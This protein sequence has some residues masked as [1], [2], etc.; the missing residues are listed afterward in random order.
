MINFKITS[1]DN[2]AFI[3]VVKPTGKSIP[4]KIG[5]I[6]RADVMEILPTGGV[7]LK[8]KG[9]FLTAK[10]EVPLDKGAS[11][12]F[13][14]A[15]QPV[16]GKELRL[17]FM[18]Y[19]DETAKGQD[20]A[21]P[22]FNFKDSA[23][24]KLIQDLSNN[25][26][27]TKNPDI[28]KIQNLNAEILKALP[29]DIT[30]LPK[31]VRGQLQNL[32]QASLK[33]TGQ[34][35]QTRLEGFI[36]ELPEQIKNLP[37]VEG[38]KKDLIVSMEKLLQTPLKS[39]LQDT[40]VALEA[41]L[42]NIATLLAQTENNRDILSQSGHEEPLKAAL[43]EALLPDAKHLQL[44]PD[45]TTLKKDM[46]A[47]LLQLRQ[48]FSDEGKAVI[49]DPAVQNMTLT[50]REGAVR[51]IDGM[52]KDIE[53]FQLLSKTTDSF[54]TFLPVSW[55]EL[56]DGEVSFKKGRSDAK[57]E[58]FSCSINLDLEKFGTL[59]IRVM[60]Y[61]NE[62]SVSFKPE[63]PEF[64]KTLDSNAA[65]LQAAFREKRLNLKAVTV[66]DIN[67]HSFEQLENLESSDR[68]ISIK[69]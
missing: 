22:F 57:G 60:M 31:D 11:V 62:F 61:N 2:E 58:S 56:K 53:T 8:I 42:K 7:T 64:Q 67:D 29:S 50:Q 55:Q 12:F 9:E 48:L 36:N 21:K 27:N 45:T 32:L 24:P 43:K 16:E 28:S 13:K 35:I 33:T 66:L 47:D 59:K 26:V 10:T 18:G 49:K 3:S 69:A 34:G 1:F 65:E 52:L 19:T 30:L 63:N 41:K 51:F 40:G 17:Q 44:Q 14:V 37:F 5:E 20:I 68:M 4:L 38:L 15:G 25:I 46:K 39:V 54:Y 23:I 6:I